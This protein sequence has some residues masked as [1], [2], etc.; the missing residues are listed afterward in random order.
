MLARLEFEVV[1]LLDAVRGGVGVSVDVA[2]RE[3][4]D[5]TVRDGVGVAVRD[6]VGVIVDVAVRVGVLTV[7]FGRDDTC[8][9][10]YTRL[11]RVERPLRATELMIGWLVGWFLLI[12]IKKEQAGETAN[13]QHIH[14]SKLHTTRDGMSRGRLSLYPWRSL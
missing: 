7:C 6:G 12:R 9:C 3:G 5:V 4:V 10:L 14:K 2:V 8:C 13:F 1:F 11:W